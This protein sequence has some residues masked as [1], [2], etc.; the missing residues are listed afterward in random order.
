MKCVVS[1]RNS[2]T[3][4]RCVKW[5][6]SVLPALPT[7]LVNCR[8]LGRAHVCELFTGRYHKETHGGRGVRCLYY[9]PTTHPPPTPHALPQSIPWPPRSVCSNIPQ[10][11]NNKNCF[12]VHFPHPISAR[13]RTLL[14]PD[15]GCDFRTQVP[16]VR[17]YLMDQE[18]H[19]EDELHKISRQLEPGLPR[20]YSE[21]SSGPGPS[22]SVGRMSGSRK[23]SLN[24]STSTVVPNFR[25]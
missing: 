4:K 10:Q 22:Y 2:T 20:R 5:S 14:F 8:S 19:T 6:A 17:E 16:E 23:L 13:R 9:L 12:A 25:C 1:R 21:T 11:V 15:S 3:S 7:F 18:I 24:R